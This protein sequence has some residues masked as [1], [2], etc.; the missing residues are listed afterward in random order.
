[1]P[2]VLPDRVDRRRAAR[3]VAGVLALC[4]LACAPIAGYF[5]PSNLIMVYLAGVVFVAIRHGFGAALFTVVGG[6]LL[7]DYIYVPPRWGFN[8]IDPQYFF[9]FAMALAVGWIVSHL[10]AQ[11]RAQAVTAE[12][13]ARRAQALKDHALRLSSARSDAAVAQALT[14][15]CA[16]ALGLEADLRQP[17]DPRPAPPGWRSVPL[18]TAEGELA[19]MLH[20]PLGAGFPAEDQQ[21]LDAIAQQSALALERAL[22]E[23]RSAQAAVQA[24]GERLRNTL[25]AGIS[26]DFRTPLTTI[27]GAVGSLLDQESALDA[28]RRRLL[29]QG[30]LQ[31]ARRLHALTS[32]LLDLNRLQEGAVQLA[33]EWCPADDLVEEAR[34]ALGTR[35]Q[36]HRLEV[37]V[38]PE[39]V[40]WCDPSLL[41]QALLNLLDNAVRHTPAGG[42]IRVMVQVR[43]PWWRLVVH[44][45]G[46]GLPPGEETAVF[47]KFHR[48]GPGAGTGLGLA[49][50][51]AVARLHG[52]HASATNGAGDGG[53]RLELVLPQPP[54]Q[55]PDDT[56]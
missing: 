5:E 4:T 31:E 8:P 52:G 23:R 29:L 47:Q 24:E 53:A 30:V 39:A 12:Q 42:R 27:V 50:C 26:H 41:G 15:A 35:L 17:G 11:A 55:D 25:L 45:D 2:E 33:P 10:A 36:A 6:L 37:D 38:D 51:E 40:V 34:A 9:T 56:P 14:D 48:S 18:Q 3:D 7:F 22:Y 49:I 28:P 54:R 20:P 19:T 1:M 13:R 16:T 44:D 43:L 46:P 21:L 32:D